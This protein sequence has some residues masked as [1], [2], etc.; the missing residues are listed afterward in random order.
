MGQGALQKRRECD[1]L[2]NE[3]KMDAQQMQEASRRT[4]NVSYA[5]LAEINHF[6]AEQ[7]SE[8]SKTFKEFLTQQISFHKKVPHCLTVTCELAASYLSCSIHRL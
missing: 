2:T 3:G 7:L 1:R 6:H 4:D 5:L 8:L